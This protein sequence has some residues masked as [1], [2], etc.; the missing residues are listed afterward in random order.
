MK[1]YSL[2][3]LI[4]LFFTSCQKDELMWIESQYVFLEQHRYGYNEVIKGENFSHIEYDGGGWYQFDELERT[5][6]GILWSAGDS[7]EPQEIKGNTKILLA[8]GASDIGD[9]EGGIAVGLFEIHNIPVEVNSLSVISIDEN[10]TVHFSYKDSSMVLSPND[11]WLAT[12]T[13][14]DTLINQETNTE[15]QEMYYD[16]LIVRYTYIDQVTNWGLLEKD[17]FINWNDLYN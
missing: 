8:T 15:T 12:T 2:F 7:L 16:T 6:A 5:L 11:E 13:K 9:V 10:G 1:N 14:L 4:T 17:E 3:L